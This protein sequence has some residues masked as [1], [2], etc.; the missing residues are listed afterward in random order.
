V[1]S[2]HPSEGG[3]VWWPPVKITTMAVWIGVGVLL[4]ALL[5]MPFF[6]RGSPLN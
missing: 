4:V 3:G 2:P 6:G 1:K 5:V